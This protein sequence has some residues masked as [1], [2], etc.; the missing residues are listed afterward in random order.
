MYFYRLDLSGQPADN[1]R[2][3]G[4]LKKSNLMSTLAIK[5]DKRF[6]DVGHRGPIQLSW[7]FK[8]W[9]LSVARSQWDGLVSFTRIF[10]PQFF[11]SFMVTSHFVL[12][13]ASGNR[14][15]FAVHFKSKHV[16]KHLHIRW[17]EQN[18]G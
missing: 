3:N 12:S 2:V 5:K 11:I 4:K 18:A 17:G 16:S 8:L 14:F 15:T 7:Q 6:Q 13:V 10:I 1:A 9:V